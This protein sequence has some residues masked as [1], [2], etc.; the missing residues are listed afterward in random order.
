[1]RLEMKQRNN[2]IRYMIFEFLPGTTSDIV[3]R[4]SIFLHFL[5]SQRPRR[6]RHV[7]VGGILPSGGCGGE[8][9]KKLKNLSSL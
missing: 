4:V 1:M 2:D 9:L 7:G 3:Y 5:H 6:F 8:A